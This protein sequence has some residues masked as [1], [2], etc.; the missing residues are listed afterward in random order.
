MIGNRVFAL[1]PGWGPRGQ[2]AS[3]YRRAPA[4]IT[5][6]IMFHLRVN[7][8]HRYSDF[9][10]HI[11]DRPKCV[12]SFM[13]RFKWLRSFLDRFLWC[14][15]KC[16]VWILSLF[17]GKH[18]CSDMA[19]VYA[20]TGPGPRMG[21]I[22]NFSLVSCDGVVGFVNY[23]M[24]YVSFNHVCLMLHIAGEAQ[25]RRHVGA[26]WATAHPWENG[27]PCTPWKCQPWSENFQAISLS[28]KV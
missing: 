19:R 13:I 4:K 21:P 10:F 1:S 28:I 23:L 8:I 12:S 11:N 9:S 17:F 14:H 27:G 15:L 25:G 16:I 20:I 24:K 22:D 5:G 18:R 2:G 6:L 7:F 26:R 3:K